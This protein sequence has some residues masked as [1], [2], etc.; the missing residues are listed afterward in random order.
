MGGAINEIKAG[1]KNV[2]DELGV[3]LNRATTERIST[4]SKTCAHKGLWMR[5]MS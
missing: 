3:C 5:R 2:V 1:R 4:V